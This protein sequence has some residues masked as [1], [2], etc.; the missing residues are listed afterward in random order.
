MTTKL[1]R[2]LHSRTW[3]TLN[4]EA[5]RSYYPRYEASSPLADAMFHC[6]MGPVVAD[7][8]K[9]ISA[10]PQQ[11]QMRQQCDTIGAQIVW[12]DDLA[13]PVLASSNEELLI[14]FEQRGMTL[15]MS[16][17]KSEA[18]LTPAGTGAKHHREQLRLQPRLE[19]DSFRLGPGQRALM[20][21]AQYKHLGTTLSAG[22]LM[23]QKSI[24]GL[25]R[26]G[27]PS[28]PCHARFSLTLL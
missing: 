26:H 17:G 3:A 7:L 25:D 20:L 1:L 15:N 19:L 11:Q 10:R 18:L 8:E 22:G 24:G 4:G 23:G 12:A 6:L 16:K 28:A 14:E 21:G 2:E 13:V 9:I 27:R 5:V